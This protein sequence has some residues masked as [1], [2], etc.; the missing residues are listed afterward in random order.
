MSW[1]F[2]V[3]AV[4]VGRFSPAVPPYLPG[5]SP[6]ACPAGRWWFMTDMDSE[7]MGFNPGMIIR[8]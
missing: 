2:D 6:F 7:E 1:A 4:Q 3:G 8:V 5:R